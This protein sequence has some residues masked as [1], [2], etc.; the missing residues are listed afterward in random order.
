MH[1]A[2]RKRNKRDCTIHRGGGEK[3]LFLD[4]I[5]QFCSDVSFFIFI[6]YKT[7]SADSDSQK[8]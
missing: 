6:I 1:D 4:F 2:S 3:E 5:D 8:A 7:C